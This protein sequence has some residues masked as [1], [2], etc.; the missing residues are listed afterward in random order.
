MCKIVDVR[1]L[2]QGADLTRWLTIVKGLAE[3]EDLPGHGRGSNWH[4]RALPALLFVI[5][6]AVNGY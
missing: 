2:G 4:S 1:R 6:P 5:Y 3:E